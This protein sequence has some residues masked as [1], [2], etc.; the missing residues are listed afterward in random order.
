[1]TMDTAGV[2]LVNSALQSTNEASR[3]G[4]FIIVAMKCRLSRR[5]GHGLCS[6]YGGRMRESPS[7]T[8]EKRGIMFVSNPHQ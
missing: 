7:Q 3:R 5:K 6:L 4:L 2:V 8:R 1:M